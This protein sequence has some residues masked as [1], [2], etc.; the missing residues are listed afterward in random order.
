MALS[1]GV[2][3]RLSARG[4]GAGA[5][6]IR[7]EAGAIREDVRE[8]EISVQ[9]LE[10]AL[11][12]FAGGAA[13][14]AFAKQS[15]ATFTE[16]QSNVTKLVTLAG[17]PRDIASAWERD[18]KRLGPALGQTATELSAGMLVVTSS[19]A[20]G[21]RA[22]ETLEQSG[23][24]AAIG[25][26][27]VGDISK[28]TTAI[29]AASGDP[30]LRASTVLDGLFAAVRE[31]AAEASELAP[32]LGKVLPVAKEFGVEFQDTL[33]AIAT[34]TRLGVSAPEAVTGLKSL[35]SGLTN[36]AQESR[37]ALEGLRDTS[38]GLAYSTDKLRRSIQEKGLAQTLIDLLGA[39]NGDAEV[40]AKAIPNIEG[41]TLALANAG[42][43]AEDYLAIEKAIHES[44]GDLDKAFAEVEQTAEHKFKAL[45]V[46]AENLQLALGAGIADGASKVADGLGSIA[47]YEDTMRQVGELIGKLLVLLGE[48]AQHTDL[49]AGA[50]AG[51]MAYKI[52][53]YVS[54]LVI[55][56]EAW[57]AGGAAAAVG[58]A[59]AGT[60]AAAAGPQIAALAGPIGIVIAAIVAA[61]LALTAWKAS[62][63][64]D[65]DEMVSKGQVFREL[66]DK[67]GSIDFKRFS[68]L[69][70]KKVTKEDLA[71]I[72]KAISEYDRLGETFAKLESKRK[73][74]AEAE[75]ALVAAQKTG[76]VYAHLYEPL[77]A[78]RAEW[79]SVKDEWLAAERG[80]DQLK[81]KL[82]EGGHTLEEYR[83]ATKGATSG[84]GDLT[85]AQKAAAKV[86]KELAEARKDALKDLAEEAKLARD[87][88]QVMRELTVSQETARR[89]ADLMSKGFS[90]EQAIEQI[91][92]LK[93][94]QIEEAQA[95]EDAAK[96]QEFFSA[97][98][99]EL[100][101]VSGKL[102]D[103]V[104]EVN[105]ALKTGSATSS[106]A[107]ELWS[108]LVEKQEALNVV[109][110]TF[111]KLEKEGAFSEDEKREWTNRIQSADEYLGSLR[112]LATELEQL[113]D[114]NFRVTLSID[115]Q[116]LGEVADGLKLP[117]VDGDVFLGEQELADMTRERNEENWKL[118][119]EEASAA[120]DFVSDEMTALLDQQ[121]EQWIDFGDSAAENM[122]ES[123]VR[124]L[125]SA[126]VQAAVLSIFSS[127]SGQGSGNWLTNFT[128]ILG[129][130]GGG[131]G[132]GT[133]W[134]SALT[135]IYKGYKAYQGGGVQSFFGGAG[136]AKEGTGAWTS[137]FVNNGANGLYGPAAGGGNIASGGL[138]ATGTALAVT[139][140][141]L[142]IV[143]AF[144]AYLDNREAKSY[145]PGLSQ[146]FSFDHRID[147][148]APTPTNIPG[149]PGSPGGGTDGGI[150]FLNKGSGFNPTPI[151]GLTAQTI[152]TDGGMARQL[153]EGAAAQIEEMRRIVEENTLGLIKNLGGFVT[154]LGS[155]NIAIRNDG[156]GF[157]TTVNGVEKFFKTF[158]EAFQAGIAGMLSAGKFEGLSAE[159]TRVLQNVETFGFDKLEEAL[160]LAKEADAALAGTSSSTAQAINGLDQRLAALG[161]TLTELEEKAREYGISEE[162]IIALRQRRID[163]EKLAFEAE[164][165]AAT[166]SFIQT[167]LGLAPQ[168][169]S[170]Q[171]LIQL[172]QAK[173]HTQA[174]ANLQAEWDALVAKGALTQAE[175]ELLQSVYNQ[176]LAMDPSQIGGGSS[177]PSGPDPGVEQR[178]ERRAQIAAEY[179]ERIAGRSE[180]A[181]AAFRAAK[182]VSDLV[183]EMDSLG[184]FSEEAKRLYAE[185][186]TKEAIDTFLAGDRALIGDA[187]AP[188][189]VVRTDYS[190]QREEAL[191]ELDRKAEAARILAEKLGVNLEELLG[192][193]YEAAE[194]RLQKL[195][196]EEVK[197]IRGD[198][199]GL[200]LDRSPVADDVQNLTDRFQELRDRIEAVGASSD[201]LGFTL[202]E[203]ARAEQQHLGKVTG[204]FLAQLVARGAQIK[205]EVIAKVRA[206]EAALE[207]Q[208]A[209]A[210]AL[211]LAEK[212]ALEQYGLSLEDLLEQIDAIDWTAPAPE[213]TPPPAAQSAAEQIA[214]SAEQA[215][216][217]L[218]DLLAEWENLGLTPLEQ[219]IR[220][221]NDR[222]QEMLEL[223]GR[224]PQLLARV[225]SGLRL[226]IQDL[227]GSLQAP[228]RDL[229][230][231]IRESANGPG[232]SG[233]RLD[234]AEARFEALVAR[235]NA[236]PY[237]FEAL[238][239]LGGAA[240]SYLNSVQTFTEGA[241]PVFERTQARILSVL[242][243]FGG[244][245]GD[246]VV[247]RLDET[248]SILRAM[249]EALGIPAP[250][251][252]LILTPTPDTSADARDARARLLSFSNPS[253]SGVQ[254]INRP[255]LPSTGQIV[256]LLAYQQQAVA[257]Q[258]EVLAE[259]R[260][261][262]RRLDRLEA[263]AYLP[264]I[265]DLQARNLAETRFGHAASDQRAARLQR[266]F[267]M[268]DRLRGQGGA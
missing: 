176:V 262:T 96:K 266:V 97:S 101:S 47:Q 218:E 148:L 56:L 202:E 50:I 186:A 230:R 160:A 26:G 5:A 131:G 215:R 117:A 53:G 219:R 166:T 57:A 142:L 29:L 76:E 137:A 69:D 267:E 38:D 58:T 159:V 168:F 237:D 16:F 61:Q 172:A 46:A 203:L 89:V 231:Q 79:E 234:T 52:F 150:S 247:G 214:Q 245:E 77:L 25:L 99:E 140:V 13:L 36:P 152:S 254:P 207:R 19:G 39:A 201:E 175:L 90:F 63:Q 107:A 241:G 44:A 223:A 129:G 187:S 132:G 62:M 141:G 239:E 264:R 22:L 122:A 128:N 3:V 91:A 238:Q 68:K 81:A 179:E 158:D 48:V 256:D 156:K 200:F 60:A 259:L 23:K 250:A 251:A 257:Q 155:F 20:R 133:G 78:L 59:A 183:A 222:W 162:G 188:N 228:L 195:R 213:V 216:Q 194:I 163:Q 80:Q 178:R 43:Q 12:A 84:Q 125:T 249:L 2:A 146:T 263:L 171:A 18:F 28:A 167:L 226:A 204:D 220:A 37:K 95:T 165:A 123:I 9:S 7:R 86:A 227:L 224:N 233:D 51:L 70:L 190:R 192:T 169:A 106:E 31:G 153:G 235:L 85:E 268:T 240:S 8:V 210:T 116:S 232:T 72:S 105:Q 21:A 93:D 64:R 45:L 242:D 15:A 136:I 206:E 217:R 124:E 73:K 185:A 109:R 104:L 208:R 139:A 4:F 49:I 229:A 119:Q 75:A 27:E 253:S 154:E 94:A 191:A 71:D 66:A 11:L 110:Q 10:E 145:T 113:D 40:L 182:A 246:P 157:K 261:Q 24:A 138:T 130:Q 180:E 265:E 41:L 258:G 181:K 147:P 173:T 164:G 209:I 211:L 82:E 197:G 205:P 55:A 114:S 243:R 67:I 161:P 126:A 149:V 193:I 221:I 74:L 244:E 144:K 127:L 103:Q 88:A 118:Y 6:E 198:A 98:S 111:L 255:L 260:L 14:I 189:D 32:A 134:I 102:R 1:Y 83:D 87:T 34:F 236:N 135:T 151:G 120:F 225:T 174:M 199:G 65:I 121:L 33:A 30:T 252:H 35:L 92:K 108:Q 112:S 54:S 184:G 100:A 42:A 170:N 177:Q 248:N 115:Q 143:A 212:G 196:D 17:I